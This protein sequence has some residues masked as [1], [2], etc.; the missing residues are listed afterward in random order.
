MEIGAIREALIDLRG[1]LTRGAKYIRYISEAN[2]NE[3]DMFE[4]GP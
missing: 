3:L 2:S 1:P 4:F